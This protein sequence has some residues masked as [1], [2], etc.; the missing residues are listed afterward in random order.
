MID[1]HIEMSVEGAWSARQVLRR[2]LKDVDVHD[3]NTGTEYGLIRR[4]VN[5]FDRSLAAEQERRA[6][7]RLEM[8]RAQLQLPVPEGDT[9]RSSR[10]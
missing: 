2:V 5:A 8:V 10:R 1:I 6:K 3:S 9:V 7:A 4:I